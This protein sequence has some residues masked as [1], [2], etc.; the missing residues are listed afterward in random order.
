MVFHGLSAARH[1]QVWRGFA[2][3]QDGQPAGGAVTRA[4][5]LQHSLCAHLRHLAPA[6]AHR[7]VSQIVTRLEAAWHISVP[8]VEAGHTLDTLHAAHQ[9]AQCQGRMP[10][11][12]DAP[13]QS[14]HNVTT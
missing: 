7:I 8:H 9:E 4:A 14:A 11:E 1:E 3:L 12:P 6:D 13:A 2:Y 5:K 10:D